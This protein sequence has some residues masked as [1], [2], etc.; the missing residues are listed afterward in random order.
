MDKSL[1]EPLTYPQKRFP[2]KNCTF[3]WP[4]HTCG[5]HGSDLMWLGWDT[6]VVLQG[7]Y[8]LSK[9][10]CFFISWECCFMI[11]ETT[12]LT[13]IHDT[14]ISVGQGP[15][16]NP[17]RMLQQLDAPNI[18]Q[19]RFFGHIPEVFSLP[20]WTSS[21]FFRVK[22]WRHC[23]AK[24]ASSTLRFQV[25]NE[26]NLL[27]SSQSSNINHPSIQSSNHPTSLGYTGYTLE[28]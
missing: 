5:W 18:L 15:N 3:S 7:E 2:Q 23:N 24:R 13:T 14:Q 9:L 16:V 25:Q 19:L 26:W 28:D 12:V 27:V 21:D 4:R 1:L 10:Y 17:W 20:T 8:S 11:H 22:T 6:A